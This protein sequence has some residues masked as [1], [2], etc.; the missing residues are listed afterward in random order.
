MARRFVLVTALLLLGICLYRAMTTDP[1]TIQ[2]TWEIAPAP[3]LIMGVIPYLPEQMLK[4]EFRSL[5]QYLA[6]NLGRDVQL[7]FAID[8]ESL[9]KLLDLDK[10]QIAWFSSNSF[11]ALKGEKPWQ[12]LCRPLRD[13]AVRHRGAIIVREDSGIKT[14]ADLRGKRFAY[15]DPHSGTGF[16]M[17]NRLFRSQN[18]DPLRFFS[19]VTF[20]GN[21]STSISGVLQGQYD[22]AAV[23]DVYSSHSLPDEEQSQQ[24]ASTATASIDA[25]SS[26]AAT[27]PL[28]DETFSGSGSA[29]KG[30]FCVDFTDWLLNDPVVVRS[31]MDLELKERIRELL[32]HM[33]A[34]P[35]GRE[36]LAELSV[37]RKWNGFIDERQVVASWPMKTVSEATGSSVVE[38]R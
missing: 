34:Y 13:G 18:I 37:L 11:D 25:L 3:P 17:P 35:G 30:L 20:T 32:V 4:R 9:G 33:N 1:D 5:T 12:A 19:E 21:H 2:I 22:A 7:N 27:L 36:V 24:G 38:T 16:V 14:L 8:Y 29:A 15:V 23:Y 10:I 28:P 26:P 6:R 31:D